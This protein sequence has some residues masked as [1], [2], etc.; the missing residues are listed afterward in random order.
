MREL[1]NTAARSAIDKHVRKHTG[2]QATGK[3]FGAC[4]TVCASLVLAYWA[5]YGQSLPATVGAAIGGCVGLYWTWAAVRRLFSLMR[6]NQEQPAVEDEAA[7][8]LAPVE[9]TP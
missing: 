2:K 8:E 4:L 5:W 7:E 6:L 9:P 3:L 1:A